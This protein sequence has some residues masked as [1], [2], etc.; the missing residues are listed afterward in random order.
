MEA[1]QNAKSTLRRNHGAINDASQ[2]API[3]IGADPT[4]YLG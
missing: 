2:S 1:L 3:P 4:F